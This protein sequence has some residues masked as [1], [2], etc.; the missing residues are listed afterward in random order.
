[1]KKNYLNIISKI[2]LVAAVLAVTSC[3]EEGGLAPEY[4][5][6]MYRSPSIE[7]YVESLTIS[8]Y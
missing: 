1:M 3:K 7:T 8:P 2:T 5:P 4:M 6:D